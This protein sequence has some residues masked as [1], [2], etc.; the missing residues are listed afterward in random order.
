MRL[1]LGRL[2]KRGTENATSSASIGADFRLFLLATSRAGAG[3]H[4]CFAAGEMAESLP[5]Y[6]KASGEVGTFGEK[7]LRNLIAA[8]VDAG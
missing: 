5:K 1:S 8:G 7:Y 2:M 3:G 4:A 6:N